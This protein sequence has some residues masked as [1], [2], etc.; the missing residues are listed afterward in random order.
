MTRYFLSFVALF[1]WS[2]DVSAAGKIPAKIPAVGSGKPSE[3]EVKG[4]G[5]G[6]GGVIDNSNLYGTVGWEYQRSRAVDHLSFLK[7]L[8][9]RTEEALKAGN[10]QRAEKLVS[11]FIFHM[12]TGKPGTVRDTGPSA[13]EWAEIFKGAALSVK[14]ISHMN[15]IFAPSPDSAPVFFEHLVNFTASLISEEVRV[16]YKPIWDS[17]PEVN[18]NSQ[19]TSAAQKVLERNKE[20]IFQSDQTQRFFVLMMLTFLTA[21]DGDFAQAKGRLNPIKAAMPEVVVNNNLTFSQDSLKTKSTQGIDYFIDSFTAQ[22]IGGKLVAL[23][24][25]I[26][27]SAT[28]AKK[29]DAE[30]HTARQEFILASK[31]KY[32]GTQLFHDLINDK[33]YVYVNTKGDGWC[34]FHAFGGTFPTT[35]TGTV[36][37]ETRNYGAANERIPNDIGQMRGKDLQIAKNSIRAIVLNRMKAL[38]KNEDNDQFFAWLKIRKIPNYKHIDDQI[39]RYLIATSRSASDDWDR[40]LN[41]HQSH[42][43]LKI[44]SRREAANMEALITLFKT[45]GRNIREAYDRYR[46]FFSNELALALNV[47]FEYDRVDLETTARLF[48]STVARETVFDAFVP[49]F[50]DDDKIQSHDRFLRVYNYLFEN[51]DKIN[52]IENDTKDKTVIVAETDEVL[53]KELDKTIDIW[54]GT[55]I[56]KV[57]IPLY[58][59]VAMTDIQMIREQPPVLRFDNWPGLFAVIQKKNVVVFERKDNDIKNDPA[60]IS[61]T[62][63]ALSGDKVE[64]VT[65]VFGIDTFYLD[66]SYPT[67]FIHK[68]PGHFS[69]LEPLD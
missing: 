48:A 65:G 11:H 51:M 46:P 27:S 6:G 2:G 29:L 69:W 52:A 42:G 3:K 30:P 41:W 20:N 32:N 25:G 1:V 62:A 36:I 16:P 5:D 14:V 37:T 39:T 22:N 35:A 64:D 49:K 59:H 38:K 15:E 53:N 12:I 23:L 18:D 21:N 68:S 58:Q 19:I 8:N 4:F 9:A 56:K 44:S 24:R 61:K 57:T 7:Y 31:E 66:P 28:I 50:K 60:L 33:K 47:P 63:S 55:P 45:K 17:L 40:P 34:F 43:D 13:D 54:V 10:L 67:V 26:I